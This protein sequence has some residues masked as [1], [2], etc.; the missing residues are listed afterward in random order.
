LGRHKIGRRIGIGR[1]GGYAAHIIFSVFFWLCFYCAFLVIIGLISIN[2]RVFLKIPLG[3][4]LA[5]FKPT[6]RLIF[7]R[8]G[9]N[10]KAHSQNAKIH[11]FMIFN[12]L[13]PS[14]SPRAADGQAGRRH[15]VA[16]VRIHT[17]S[18]HNPPSPWRRA[19]ATTGC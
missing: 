18:R 19:D 4:P 12:L 1:Y 5:I 9:K 6:L 8:A 11:P 3:T 10:A 16:R 14:P 7:Y 15:T 17:H 13:L 2:F